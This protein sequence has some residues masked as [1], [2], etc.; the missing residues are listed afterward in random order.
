MSLCCKTKTNAPIMYEVPNKDMMKSEIMPHSSVVKHGYASKS[1]WAEAIQCSIHKQKT[2]CRWPITS[3]FPR[4]CC[5]CMWAACPATARAGCCKRTS[6][7]CRC[8]LARACSIIIFVMFSVENLTL[9]A[10]FFS[11]IV[12]LAAKNRF[13]RGFVLMQNGVNMWMQRN[14]YLFKEV[15]ICTNFWAVYSKI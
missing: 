13:S 10:P 12:H 15:A 2:A 4:C 8:A 1:E 14:E 6:F 3:A 7:R 5:R 11:P 9:W